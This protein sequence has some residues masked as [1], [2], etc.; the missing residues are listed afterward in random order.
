MWY[1]PI[2]LTNSTDVFSLKNSFLRYGTNNTLRFNINNGGS[3]NVSSTI[4][5]I[6][7]TL[8]IICIDGEV[9]TSYCFGGN[10]FIGRSNLTGQYFL[11]N[12]NSLIFGSQTAASKFTLFDMSISTAGILSLEEATRIYN[13]EKNLFF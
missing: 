11:P 9:S 12:T 7:P 1:I 2:T 4:K 6:L 3:V 10:T 8:Y 5:A 13:S